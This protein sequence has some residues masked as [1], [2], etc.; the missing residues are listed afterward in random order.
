MLSEGPVAVGF[1]LSRSIRAARLTQQAQIRS[2]YTNGFLIKVSA[3]VC[4]GLVDL[5]GK[6]DCKFMIKKPKYVPAENN[7]NKRTAVLAKTKERRKTRKL[8]RGSSQA[9][10]R[11]SYSKP[12]PSQA[13]AKTPRHDK[14][15]LPSPAINSNRNEKL[16]FRFAIS[17]PLSS[18]HG[19][20]CTR[21]LESPKR[22][23]PL[24]SECHG[25]AA[26]QAERGDALVFSVA[27]EGIE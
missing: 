14:A 1:L 7:Q 18:S 12:P 27:F 26:A 11:A 22:S 8:R 9:K 17:G 13:N 23:D 16:A 3:A 21:P 6:V 20:N 10:R 5:P 25:I 15:M 19:A 2:K 4:N 24:D